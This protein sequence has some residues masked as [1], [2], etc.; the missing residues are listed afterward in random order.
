MEAIILI[1][2]CAIGLFLYML[3]N[4]KNEVL[5]L[6]EQLHERDIEII[7]LQNLLREKSVVTQKI[8]HVEVQTDYLPPPVD[9]KIFVQVIFNKDSKKCYDY[10]LGKNYDVHVGDFVEV[11]VNNTDNGK[12]EWAVA[13]VVYISSPGETSE[14]AKSAIKRKSDYR[15]W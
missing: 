10:F 5:Q 7:K 11:Y 12:P 2:L 8:S 1:L 13:K 9:D 3:N 4:S 15:K 6:K 14:Y